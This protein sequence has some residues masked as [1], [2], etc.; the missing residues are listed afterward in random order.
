MLGTLALPAQDLSGGVRLTKGELGRGFFFAPTVFTDVDPKT[1]LAQEEIFGPVLSIIPCDSLDQAI[2]IVNGAKHGLS[3][4]IY[5]QDVNRAFLAMRDLH[6]GILCV[7]SPTTGSE[8]HLPFGGT[9]QTGNGR[10]EA[11][12][13]ALEIFSEWKAITVDYSGKVPKAQGES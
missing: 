6:T 2:E 12:D 10:R 13:A 4:S 8:I 3:S 1:R 5:T 11:G 7:N 9:R